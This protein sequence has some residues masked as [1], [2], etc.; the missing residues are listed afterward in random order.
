MMQAASATIRA[1]L[2]PLG[3]DMVDHNGYVLGHWA[4]P[5]A[6]VDVVIGDSA[7]IEIDLWDCVQVDGFTVRIVGLVDDGWD[8]WVTY[9]QPRFFGWTC[10]T[11]QWG[12]LAP[13]AAILAGHMRGQSDELDDLTCDAIIATLNGTEVA[14]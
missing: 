4:D 12:W 3:W 7:R 14:A 11:G 6:V 9:E 8:E 10:L 1:E 5:T 2:A 13:A